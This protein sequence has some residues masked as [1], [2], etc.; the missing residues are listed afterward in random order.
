MTSEKQSGRRE[1]IRAAA[2]AA[3]G[4]GVWLAATR[5]AETT[6]WQIDPS[7]CVQCGQCATHCVMNPSAVKCVH[8]TRICGYCDLC[9][10]FLQP[11]SPRLD[12]GAENELCPTAAVKRSFV[13]DP[14]FAYEI[15]EVLCVGCG[16][17]VKGCRQFGNGSLYLQIKRDLCQNC[18]ECAIARQCP[19][20]AVRRIPLSQAY[21]LKEAGAEENP[22]S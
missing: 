8:A 19:A 17:C 18:N 21:F 11:G 10:G 13:E 15:D 9:S 20:E 14:Y 7:K 4:G 12:T 3:L 6:V 5:S 16:K 22:A 2:A 1:F